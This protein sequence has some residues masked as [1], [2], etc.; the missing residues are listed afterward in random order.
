MRINSRLIRAH[1]AREEHRIESLDKAL[2]PEPVAPVRPPVVVKKAMQEEKAPAVRDGQLCFS[3]Y[4]PGRR[5][6]HEIALAKRVAAGNGFGPCGYGTGPLW[7]WAQ[8][9]LS[10]ERLRFKRRRE[11]AFERAKLEQ[12]AKQTE[13]RMEKILAC[14]ASLGRRIDGLHFADTRTLVGLSA[15]LH[16]IEKL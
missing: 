7:N 5:V 14:I 4:E 8:R 1:F 11:A 16:R 6:P 12:N 10:V 2:H 9:R 13:M 3:F 15:E